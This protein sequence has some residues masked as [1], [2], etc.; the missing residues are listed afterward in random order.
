MPASSGV[1]YPNEANTISQGSINPS[2]DDTN[3]YPPSSMSY[4]AGEDEVAEKRD[5]SLNRQL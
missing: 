5:I 4:H 2:E 3:L 1:C